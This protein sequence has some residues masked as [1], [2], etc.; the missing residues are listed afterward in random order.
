MKWE[1]KILTDEDTESLDEAGQAEWELV[2]VVYESWHNLRERYDEHQTV[3][4]FKR[5]TKRH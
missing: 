4:Y 2:S 5:P 1:Y 3:Y